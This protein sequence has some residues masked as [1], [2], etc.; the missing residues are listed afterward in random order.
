MHVVQHHQNA[1][2]GTAGPCTTTVYYTARQA[3][4]PETYDIVTSNPGTRKTRENEG[5]DSASDHR[6]LGHHIHVEVHAGL[7]TLCVRQVG[8]V[9][10]LPEH[11]DGGH[12]T[13]W[14]PWLQ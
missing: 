6:L 14:L 4:T 8:A 7:H 13:W 2:V 5:K 3:D 9:G 11:E 1:G 12:D 10:Y